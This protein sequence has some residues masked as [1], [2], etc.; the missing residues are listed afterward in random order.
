MK[1]T[2]RIATTRPLPDPDHDE[3]LLLEALRK[4]GIEA[5]MA[6]WKDEAEGWT[7]GSRR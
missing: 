6:L 4:Q 1:P 2:L 5:R 3:L 7:A